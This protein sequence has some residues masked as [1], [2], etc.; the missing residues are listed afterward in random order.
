MSLLQILL[1]SLAV[2]FVACFLCRINKLV[3]TVFEQVLV[4]VGPIILTALSFFISIP[5]NGGTIKYFTFGWPHFFYVHYLEDILDKTLI[6]KWCFI[7]GRLFSYVVSDYVFYLSLIFLAV[8]LLRVFGNK[9]RRH[10]H[11]K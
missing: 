3:L 4:S 9:H 7:P 10:R 5:K 2:S 1:I 6:N 8:V 11:H